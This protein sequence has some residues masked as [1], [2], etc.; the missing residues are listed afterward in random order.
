LSHGLKVV[1]Q[2][3]QTHRLQVYNHALQ[4]QNGTFQWT[5]QET[6]AGIDLSSASVAGRLYSVVRQAEIADMDGDGRPEAVYLIARALYLFPFGTGGELL[7][8]EVS[9]PGDAV[10]FFLSPDHGYIVVN[11]LVEG[12]G[13]RSVLLKYRNS[14][15]VIIQDDMNLWLSFHDMD[16]DGSREAL[17]GQTFNLHTVWGE[18][19]YRLEVT[20]SGIEY[21][22]QLAVPDDFRTGWAEWGD[23]DGN[24]RMDLCLFDRSGRAWLYED[25]MLRWSTPPGVLRPG[26]QNNTILHSAVADIYGNGRSELVFAGALNAREEDGGSMD[27]LCCVRW[28]NGRFEM[29]PVTRPLQAVV[30]GISVLDSSMMVAVVEPP[31]EEDQEPGETVMYRLRL[32]LKQN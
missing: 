30:A 29:K 1:G 21:L 25:G 24:G 11:V 2:L 10:G 13:L 17:L 20:S 22:E 31:E 19:V 28:E 6:S 4:Q 26:G 16:G 15:L 3:L 18:N 14:A 9:G 12:V 27:I 8:W 23:V 5:R 7:S 32:P